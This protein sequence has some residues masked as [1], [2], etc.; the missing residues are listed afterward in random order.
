MR[1]ARQIFKNTAAMTLADLV[2][3]AGSMLL[4]FLIARMLQ[5]SGLGI[6]SAAMA[7]YGVIAIASSMG[8]QDFLVREIA[9]EPDKTN[10]Y[11]VHASV[12]GLAVSSSVMAVFF[13]VLPLLGHS[14]E[15]A[16]STGVVILAI[17]PGTLNTI[18][19]AVFVAHQRVEFVLFTRFLGTLVNVALSLVLLARGYGVVSL[20]VAFVV[21]EYLMMFCFYFLISRYIAHIRWEFQFSFARKLVWEMRVFAALSFLSALFAQPEVIILSLVSDEEQ[22]GYYSAAN[23][24]VGFWYLVSQMY[25]ANVYPALSRSYHLADGKFQIM[26]DKSI[27]YLLAVS[28]P[29]T[30]GMASAA[31]PAIRLFYGPGFEAA[32]LPLQIMAFD[33]P[34][35]YV[36]AVLW[37]VLAARNRQD[38]VLWVRIITLSTRLGGGYLMMRW[39]GVLGASISVLTNLVLNTLLL[40]VYIRRSGIRLRFLALGWRFALAATV[41]SVLAWVLGPQVHLWLLVLIAAV[42]YAGLVVLLKGFDA[43]DLALFRQLWQPKAPQQQH[44]EL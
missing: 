40:A 39:W 7:Y 19:N 26:Q 34:L 16:S 31:A 10:R 25:M 11:V 43:D 2:A 28:L 12:A 27:K 6:Y 30:A 5:A 35:G 38:A 24:L 21:V 37:R 41:M 4:S 17:I 20:L 29:L 9:R 32:V 14:A 44:G 3:R 15:L 1:Q 13:L 22:I 18:Q 8:T 42:V 36:S 23:K 33:I